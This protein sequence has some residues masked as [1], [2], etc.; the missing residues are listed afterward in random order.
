M[1]LQTDE[2]VSALPPLY[3]LLKHHA[4]DLRSKHGVTRVKQL[5][6]WVDLRCWSTS[7][8]ECGRYTKQNK[9]KGKGKAKALFGPIYFSLKDLLFH[10][11]LFLCCCSLVIRHCLL[12]C[13][14]VCC[15]AYVC[16]CRCK[17]VC[18][19]VCVWCLE[20]ESAR[21]IHTTATLICSGNIVILVQSTG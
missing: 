9:K 14:W 17:H 7:S 11:S 4:V 10:E 19:S 13:L 20:R 16:V 6:L 21:L 12:V 5:L 8:S 2:L 18:M 1:R 3:L 15:F